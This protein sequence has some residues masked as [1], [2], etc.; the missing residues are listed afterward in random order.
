M[1]R[2][3][4][5]LSI[6][7]FALGFTCKAYA[8][9]VTSKVIRFSLE[10]VTD[11]Y[12]PPELF[13]DI[14]FNDEN[15]NMV[16]EALEKGNIKVRITNKGGAADK[17]DVSLSPA[18][19]MP[20]LKIEK[21]LFTTSIKDHGEATIDVPIS[22]GVSIPTDSVRINIRISE[23][24]GYDINAALVL[25][26]FEYQ[27]SKIKMQGVDI[28]DSGRG[29]RAANG[30]P[31]GKMQKGDI[32]RATVTLQNIGNGAAK[33]VKYTIKSTDPN[34]IL[35][36]ANGPTQSI[37]GEL[38]EMKIGE[39]KEVAFRLSAN[40]N[41]SGKGRYIPVFITV[42][43]PMGFGNIESTNVP[44]SLGV[45]PEKVQLVK[46]DGDINKLIAL[47]QS[48]VY[49]SSSKVSSNMK[50]KDINL[51]PAGSPIY[52]DAIAIVIGAEENGYGVPPAPY[53]ARDAKVMAE[54]FKKSLGVQDIQL[55][56]NKEVTSTKLS[57]IFDANFGYLA[58]AVKPG[59][60]DV[61]VY[62]SGH[63]MPDGE[64][65]SNQ[66][67]YLFPYDARKEMVSARGYSLSSLYAN[68]DKLNAK[69]VTV[70]LD[71]CF[72]G[73]SRQSASFETA[74][75]SNAKGARIKNVNLSHQPWL[76]NPNF[77]VFTSSTDS[78]TSLGYD[79]SQSGLFTYYMA[80]GL[81]G[82]AD[83]DEDGTITLQELVNYVSA[84]VSETAK[85]I[86]MGSQTPQFMGEGSRFIIEKLR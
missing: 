78:E 8:Q 27:K 25:S 53:A 82:D 67:I 47:Q 16:L 38:G 75:I 34:V 17:V 58:N 30:A 63:G 3:L 31:D 69:S 72:S 45:A 85:Q 73:S 56:T 52:S 28:I 18:K 51:A 33:N 79:Q 57:D 32:V 21:N 12:M 22:A 29:L 62:Y 59:V 54:Y 41:Y 10:D 65:A 42:E 86:R 9:S 61:F 20:G 37:S 49:S 46:V 50:I 43:E 7:A 76:T 55:I 2:F 24:M 40:N 26:T 11:V 71:A 70:F 66:D 84:Q 23:A 48:Q 39:G 5:I 68:L 1:K 14:E 60:T 77:R 81:Q 15:Q 83:A 44:I 64:N 36:E 4:T 13:V 35:Y 74:P 80:V 19:M 6:T